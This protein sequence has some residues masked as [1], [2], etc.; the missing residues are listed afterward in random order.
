[1]CELCEVV[2]IDAS[3]YTPKPRHP[4]ATF[5]N[6]RNMSASSGDVTWESAEALLH[7][8]EQALWHAEYEIRVR[9]AGLTPI[10]STRL[11]CK[12]SY[13]DDENH[14]ADGFKVAKCYGQSHGGNSACKRL[15][16]LL[17]EKERYTPGDTCGKGSVAFSLCKHMLLADRQQAQ[18]QS[19]V[20]CKCFAATYLMLHGCV[21]LKNPIHKTTLLSA[22][23]CPTCS[24]CIKCNKFLSQYYWMANLQKSQPQSVG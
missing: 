11:T 16:K 7:R 8:E 21:H 13:Y 10:E 6:L 24:T 23:L 12:E 3:A 1:M 19:G 17:C 2:C 5:A 14:Q 18:G 15:L 20:A 4:T 9:C 22:T